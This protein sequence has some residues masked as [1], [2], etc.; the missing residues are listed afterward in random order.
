VNL[1]NNGTAT[2]TGTYVVA[3]YDL[4]G[5]LVQVI[6]TVGE[7]NG[8]QSG[9][10]YLSPFLTFSTTFVLPPPGSYLMAVIHIP[11][12][13][14]TAELTGSTAAFKNPIK[15]TI[16]A[17]V[18]QADQYESN[19]TVGTAYTLPASFSGNPMSIVS[20]GSNCHLDSDYD[21]FKIRFPANYN[22]KVATRLHDS[23]SSTNGNTYTLDA[24]FS[25]STDSVTW[26]DAYD[27]TIPDSIAVSGGS[28]LFFHVAPYF[29]GGTGSYALE[30]GASRTT[31]NG[32]IGGGIS[33]SIAVYPNPARHFINVDLNDFKDRISKI[34]V[35]NIQGKEQFS[36]RPDPAKRSLRLP[37]NN[38]SEGTYF[39]QLKTANGVVSK[40]ISVEK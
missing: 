7:P 3:L 22:Y 25:Y 29:P 40:K 27:D 10:T 13:T 11:D 39:M 36:V 4:E 33:R 31:A 9:Y 14:G 26:S 2:F 38:M 32:V 1:V 24:L 35:L 20:T 8:L 16:Q 6:D 12:A 15:I 34:Q 5:T 17:P 37:L 19:N 21:Y 23:Y 30:V 18:I 28:T